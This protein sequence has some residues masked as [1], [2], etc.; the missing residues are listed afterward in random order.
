V[1]KNHIIPLIGAMLI[2]FFGHTALA[3]PRAA[4][5]QTLA[6]INNEFNQAMKVGD[7]HAAA[8][9]IK[10]GLSIDPNWKDGLWKAGLVFYQEK[11]FESARGY[12]DRLAQLTPKRGPAWALLGMCEFQLGDFQA[13][14]T[15][16]DRGDRLGIPTE[17]GLRLSALLDDAIAQDNL[18]NFGTALD[19]LDKIVKRIPLE[20]QEERQ[21]IIAVYGYAAVQKPVNA[22]LSPQQAALLHGVGAAWYAKTCGDR[23]LAGA[24]IQNLLQEHPKEPMLHY[25]YGI[26]LTDWQDYA[27]AKK[28]FQA[29]LAVN[30][31]SLVARLALSYLALGTSETTQALPYA[32]EA[33]KM[34]PD[35]YLPHFILGRLLV[36]TGQL[37]EG[38]QQLEIA[39]KLSPSNSEIV[40]ILATTYRRLGRTK[41]AEGEFK[42]FQRLKALDKNLT[43]EA[44]TQK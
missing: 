6:Q 37:K 34:S 24:L 44:P 9:L 2:A 23:A 28:E 12:L 11:Q 26:M 7:L 36:R 33:V 13:A 3:T 32:R 35:T 40:Y 16:I 29:E 27:A 10:R 42:E 25:A 43:K 18:G 38:C 20:T 39:S 21:R 5:A 14:A 19:L 30:P 41:D 22:S 8:A 15:H 17:S 31:G 4:A 1:G